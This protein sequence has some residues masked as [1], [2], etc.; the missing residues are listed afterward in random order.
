[1]IDKNTSKKELERIFFEYINKYFRGGFKHSHDIAMTA[2]NELVRRSNDEFTQESKQ[3][4]RASERLARAAIKLAK[5]STGLTIAAVLLAAVTIW[6]NQA[7]MYSDETW[8]EDQ[9]ELLQQIRNKIEVVE[10]LRKLQQENDS[11]K[12]KLF[13]ADMLI[14]SHK[15]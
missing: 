14:Q 5:F 8:Q 3:A 13:K 11:L 4:W 7:D 12:N 9:L 2:H 1:M 15:K 10:D 6:Y